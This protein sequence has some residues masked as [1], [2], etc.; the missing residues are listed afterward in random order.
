MLNQGYDKH[1]GLSRQSIILMEN[2][3]GVLIGPSRPHGKAVP[4]AAGQ[5]LGAARMLSL[6]IQET[7]ESKLHEELAGDRLSRSQWKLLEI[8]ATTTVG[9]VTEVAAYQGVSTAAASKAVE[10]LVRLNLLER[11]VDIRDRRH[12]RLSLSA[13]GGSLVTAYLRHLDLRLAELLGANGSDDLAEIG[14]VLERITVSVLSAAD[15]LS[16]IC[17]QCELN[18]REGCLMEATLHRECLFYS[19]P[20]IAPA[21]QP[22]PAVRVASAGA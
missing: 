6:A 17:I 20:R 11:T 16:Q 15:D 2:G 21:R 22:S 8:F 9:T 12:I 14:R 18:A 5:L 7:V 1:T 10:R 19:V 3:A 4:R 13:E